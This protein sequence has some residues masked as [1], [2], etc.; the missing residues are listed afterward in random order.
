ME[1]VGGERTRG[2]DVEAA[3]RV[4]LGIVDGLHDAGAALVIDGEL[5]AAANEERFTRKKMQGGMPMHS[6]RT[7]LDQGGVR[8]QD[9]EAL[10]VGGVATPTVAT[11]ILRPLQA[12]YAGSQ[13]IC[14]DRPW[15]PV[16]VVGDLVRYR[17]PL[18]RS[19]GH[20]AAGRFE[21]RLAV[22]ALRRGLPPALRRLGITMV[23]HHLAHAESAWRCSGPGDWLVVTADAHGDGRSL[24]VWEA[25]EGMTQP[26]LRF[27][28]GVRQSVGAFYSYVTKALGFRPG[29]HEGKVL[30]LAARGDGR[31]LPFAFPFAWSQDMTALRFTGSW[32]IP[33]ARRLAR[34]RSYAREDVAAWVQHGT[35]EIFRALV[36]HWR[37]KLEVDQIAVAGGVFANVQINGLIAADPAV[38]RLVVFPHMGDGG[39]AAG[40]ALHLAQRTPAPLATACLGPELDVTGLEALLDGTGCRVSRPED[41]DE[42][43]LDTLAR[44]HPVARVVGRMEFGPRALGHR[45]ILAPPNDPALLD[46]LGLA[47]DRDAFMPFAPIV[48]I[49]E[50][51]ASF[52]HADVVRDAARFMTVA[53][54]ASDGFAEHCPGAVHVDRTARPQFVSREGEPEL[55]RLLTRVLARCGWPALINTSF[56][57]HEEPIVASPRDAL[58][59]FRASR[60]PRMRLGPFIVDHPAP[61]AWGA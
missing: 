1:G 23:D 53:L 25:R 58:R 27:E 51:R 4:V 6:M 60:L 45:S 22:P 42:A 24:G 8:P 5:V 18:T 21:G 26:A 28:V 41:P 32:G 3:P 49:E 11:R 34:L 7:V 10:A 54:P 33:G 37:R 43:L 2:P 36:R 46:T 39:L 19:R 16:D 29:R 9:L 20:A 17:L 40:A 15:H 52:R 59:A 56:N 14:F 44:G 57:L 38:K 55:H 13:G 50:G 48:R 61:R 30:G 31:R 12:L 35:E 47:L